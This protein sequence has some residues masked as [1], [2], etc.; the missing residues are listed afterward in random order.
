MVKTEL[1]KNNQIFPGQ[2]ILQGMPELA[3]VFDVNGKLIMWNDNVAKIL[4]YTAKELDHKFVADFIAPEDREKTL[5]AMQKIFTE[6]K[7][8]TVAYNLLTKSGSELP[9]IGS[10]SP[11]LIDG[12]K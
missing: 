7:E 4:G 6:W 2:L 3:Y 12:N 9:Y 5:V 10:G 11:L 8:Q 1:P